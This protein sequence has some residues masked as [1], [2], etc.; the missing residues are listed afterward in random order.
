MTWK[1][2][3]RD[4]TPEQRLAFYELVDREVPNRSTPYPIPQALAPTPVAPY[5]GISIR[6]VF[7][8]IERDGHVHT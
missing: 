7:Y 1:Q 5:I 2:W 6:G 4:C 8:G 3:F